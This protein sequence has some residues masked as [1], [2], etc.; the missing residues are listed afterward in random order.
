[1][2]VVTEEQL[3]GRAHFFTNVVGSCSGEL[4]L[5]TSVHWEQRADKDGKGTLL[6][7]QGDHACPW[8]EAAL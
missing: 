5:G 3:P 8:K 2:A 4:G 6:I 1:M 7:S